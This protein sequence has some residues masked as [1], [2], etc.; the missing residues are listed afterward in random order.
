MLH[1]SF[2]QILRSL[3]EHDTYA[4][5]YATF[6]LST[7]TPSISLQDEV[8]RLEEQHQTCSDDESDSDQVIYVCACV[9]VD[10]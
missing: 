6:L 5:A 2:R 4:E 9:C 10:F 7:G 8:C 3:G 1:V